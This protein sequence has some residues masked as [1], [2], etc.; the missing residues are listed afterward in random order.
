MKWR[1]K[2]TL[3]ENQV[4]RLQSILLDKEKREEGHHQFVAQKSTE[5]SSLQLKCLSLQD[6]NENFQDQTKKAIEEK[7][8]VQR[9]YLQVVYDLGKAQKQLNSIAK[10][11]A[12]S[13]EKEFLL[14]EIDQLQKDNEQLQQKLKEAEVRLLLSIRV[15]P[16]HFNVARYCIS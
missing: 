10:E 1:E 16:A 7:E 15:V 4:Q 3:L 6:A 2:H 12:A 11:T 8:R 13:T 5:L 14:R 9:D